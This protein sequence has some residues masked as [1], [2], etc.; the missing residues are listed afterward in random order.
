VRARIDWKYALA[1]ALTDPGFDAS[2]LSEFRQR[3]ITG[4]AA[5]LLCETMLTRFCE[6]GLLKA[7]GRQRTDSTHVLAA[8]QMRN[9]LE[10]IGETLR[11]ARNVLAT[12]APDWLQSWVPAVWFDRYRQRFADYRLPPEKPARDTLA[13]QIDMDGRQLLWAI[14]DPATPAWLREVP[15]IQTLRQVWLQQF[16]ASPD[17]QPVR[18]RHADD[19]PPAPLLISSPSDPEAR[20][21]KKRETEW[22]GYK[23]PI[24]ATCDDETP[25]LITDVLTT[26]ATTSDGAVLPTLPDHL[27]TRPVP[28]RAQGVEAGDGR[29]A[30]LWTSRT[31]HGS[32]LRGPV[33]GAQGYG[34]RAVERLAK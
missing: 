18:W 25:N 2:V 22:T 20:Y 5:L 17:D 7:K 34:H 16:Y 15:A 1:L 23:V 3:L 13:T 28:P 30:H 27:A 11:H 26:P 32:D 10:C 19:V 12:V 14:Y 24:T 33:P 29:A 21:G 6:Q 4:H 8:I 31:V 9:R